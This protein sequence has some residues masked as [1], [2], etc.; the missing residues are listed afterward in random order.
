MK[1]FTKTTFSIIA[2]L[3]LSLF[4]VQCNNAKKKFIEL[5]V[6]QLNKQCPLNMGNGMTMEKCSMEG[7][8]TMKT[9]FTVSDPSTL[10][11]TEEGKNVI[12][13]ALKNTPEF[14]QIKEFG[15]TYIY[16]Y[17]DAEKKLVGEI[18]I[19]PEDYK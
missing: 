7:G 1:Q 16:A 8:N 11:I 9:D 5:Q 2:I 19:T 13:T 3:S 14:E 4:F 15:I 6:E 12:V 17:Y 18:K 10:S